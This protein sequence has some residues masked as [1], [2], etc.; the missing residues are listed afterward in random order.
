MMQCGRWRKAV[1]PVV[2]SLYRQPHPLPLSSSC[3]YRHA[4]S[5]TKRAHWS[6]FNRGAILG[7]LGSVAGLATAFHCYTTSTVY[8]SHSAPTSSLPRLTLY[9][10][11]SC[12]FCGKVRAFCDY[13][14]LD[15][16]S[17]SVNPVSRKEIQFSK[18]KKLPLV[19]VDGEKVCER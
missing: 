14:N 1:R 2:L 13:N 10:Y 5:S 12:P 8:C 16:T 19:V 3:L 18:S 7:S 17:V 6:R 9:E 15:Y 4:S 11:P